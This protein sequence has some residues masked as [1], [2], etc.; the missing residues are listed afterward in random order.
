MK[1]RE[2]RPL[3]LVDIAVPR[4]IEPSAGEI[5]HVYLYNIDDLKE[6][7]STNLLQRSNEIYKV[8]KIITE[9]VLTFKGYLRSRDVSPIIKSM[10]GYFEDIVYSELERTIARNSLTSHE[11]KILKSFTT[12]MLHKMLHTPTVRLKE[13]ARNSGDISVIEKIKELFHREEGERTR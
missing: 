5:P 12:S 2:G 6:V 11:K 7:A 9:E 10:R 4:D 1:S 13:M 3:F 8:K